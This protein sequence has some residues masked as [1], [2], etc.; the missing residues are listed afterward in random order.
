MLTS[1]FDGARI[2]ISNPSVGKSEIGA[3]CSKLLLYY[4]SAVAN[5]TF[6]LVDVSVIDAIMVERMRANEEIALLKLADLLPSH[7]FLAR[8]HHDF[9]GEVLDVLRIALLASVDEVGIDKEHGIYSIALELRSD[10]C[11]AVTK[12]IIKG[13][14]QSATLHAFA[15]ANHPDGLVKID[16]VAMLV[17]LGEQAAEAFAI[18][19]VIVVPIHHVAVENV[20]KGGR[21]AERAGDAEEGIAEEC[22]KGIRHGL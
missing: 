17:E 10:L 2:G 20:D 22:A 11:I 5:L 15:A 8:T 4:T 14:G 6:E 7:R 21:L 19:I 12:T 13:E 3:R 18:G 16:E 1:H 9:F